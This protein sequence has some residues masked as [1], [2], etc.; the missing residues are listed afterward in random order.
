MLPSFTD[1][2][3]PALDGAELMDIHNVCLGVNICPKSYRWCP[4]VTICTFEK[5]ASWRSN[6]NVLWFWLNNS[7]LGGWRAFF[8]RVGQFLLQKFLNIYH[9]K[10]WNRNIEASQIFHPPNLKVLNVI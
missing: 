4:P 3:D 7:Y 1:W 9:T 5:T 6:I 2:S 8:H 10:R